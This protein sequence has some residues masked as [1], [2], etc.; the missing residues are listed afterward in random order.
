MERLSELCAFDVSPT[1]HSHITADSTET[2][3][4]QANVQWSLV[5]ACVNVIPL[6]S[7]VQILLS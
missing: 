1:E 2:E 6:L 3:G 5:V 7:Q 4:M